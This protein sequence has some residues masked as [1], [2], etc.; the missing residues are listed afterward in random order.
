MQH[1]INYK[2]LLT[3]ISLSTLATSCSNQ[4]IL[5]GERKELTVHSKSVSI[6]PSE[7]K[8]SVQLGTA[9]SPTEWTM[10]GYT[11]SHQIPHVEFSG[12]F[13]QVTWF[14]A[15]AGEAKGKAVLYAPIIKNNRLYTIGTNA[16]VTCYDLSSKATVWSNAYVSDKKLQRTLSTTGITLSNNHL[17]LTTSTNKAIAVN[18]ANGKTVWEQSLSDIS[19]IPPRVQDDTVFY[20]NIDNVLEALNTKTGKRAWTYQSAQEEALLL[21]GANVSTTSNKII[22]PFSSGEI[23]AFTPAGRML[24]NDQIVSSDPGNII[25]DIQHVYAPVVVDGNI[26]YVSSH[27]GALIAYNTTTGKRIWEQPLIVL[28][29]PTVTPSHMFVVDNQQRLVCL[30]KLTGQVK[31]MS[32]LQLSEKDFSVS[33]AP[34]YWYGPMLMSGKLTVFGSNGTV[35][36]LNPET[37]KTIQTVSLNYEIAMAPIVVNKQC[38]IVTPKNNVIV[39]K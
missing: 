10:E 39:Y 19:R 16:Q 21:G 23:A 30:N 15:G 8:Q 31:W 22:A 37:G 12:N 38:Y 11:P 26:A 5:E 36:R 14:N 1:K 2:K 9:I 27:A 28:Q 6:D 4:V 33:E 24:W 13:N 29:T 34:I 17:F 35:L 7:Q 18:A 20:S 32:Q 3:L 25:N